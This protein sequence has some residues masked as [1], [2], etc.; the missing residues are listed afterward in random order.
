MCADLGSIKTAQ[1]RHQIKV[2]RKLNKPDSAPNDEL[3]I[4]EIILNKVGNAKLYTE[5]PD[6]KVCIIKW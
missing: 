6:I 2:F 4:V 3:G 1:L 5:L